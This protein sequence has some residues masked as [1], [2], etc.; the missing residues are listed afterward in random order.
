MDCECCGRYRPS[1]EIA[2][3]RAADGH[4]L[5][6]CARCRRLANGRRGRAP[7]A[8]AVPVRSL[9]TNPVAIASPR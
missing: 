3:L 9:Q 8:D 7:S 5:M 6:A 2:P 4:F 1:Q